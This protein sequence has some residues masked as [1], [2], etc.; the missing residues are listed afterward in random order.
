MTSILHRPSRPSLGLL[1]AAALLSLASPANAEM[2]L[3]QVIVDLAAGTSPHQDIE[4]WNSGSERIYVMAEP[5]EIVSA[6]KADERRIQIADPEQLGLLVAPN[7]L[8][9][10]PGERKL[11]RI[12][13]VAQRTGKERIYRV[14]IKPVMGD[15]AAAGSGLKILVGYDALVIVRPTQPHSEITS[16]R[17]GNLL[18]LH[19]NGNTNAELFDGKQCDDTGKNCVNLPPKRLYAGTSWDQTLTRS[20]PVSYTVKTGEAV[21]THTF[22]P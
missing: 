18:T 8:I 21:A 11:I 6:G 1:L 22:Q 16:S 2:V 4:V 7:R 12:V 20:A 14:A 5:S 9:M 19:N 10:E 3:S 15:I 17:N 13:T